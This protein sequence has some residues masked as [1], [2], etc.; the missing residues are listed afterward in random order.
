MVNKAL[1][2]STSK[3]MDADG[4]E[5]AAQ[6]L[7]ISAVL[8]H[9]LLMPA[10]PPENGG[11]TA[12]FVSQMIRCFSH[13]DEFADWKTE[14]EKLSKALRAA[15]VDGGSSTTVK[16]LSNP[17]WEAVHKCL[18]AR[19]ESKMDVQSID[20]L[21]ARTLIQAAGGDFQLTQEILRGIT[22]LFNTSKL[23]RRELGKFEWRNLFDVMTT[24][25]SL[26]EF[27]L[28]LSQGNCRTFGEQ[29]D[30][31]MHA[32]LP[33]LSTTVTLRTLYNEEAARQS[34]LH[35]ITEMSSERISVQTETGDGEGEGEGEGNVEDLKSWRR[36]DSVSN[37]L[38]HQSPF[39]PRRIKLG[40]EVR[41][42]TA[43]AQLPRIARGLS[44]RL[45]DAS[46]PQ[47]ISAS[48]LAILQT[49]VPVPAP[50]MLGL[51]LAQR[52]DEHI[53][54]DKNSLCFHVRRSH[55]HPTS[56]NTKEEWS[57]QIPP[58]V[59]TEFEK[60]FK[61]ENSAKFLAD[62]LMTDGVEES[63]LLKHHHE[64][65][66]ICSDANLQCWPGHWVHGLRAAAVSVL[67]SEL[68][69]AFTLGIPGLAS[70]GS[71]HYFHPRQVDLDAGSKEWYEHLGL[72]NV[73]SEQHL[74]E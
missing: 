6:P 24:G 30:R 2:L 72:C 8:R 9:G 36:G 61:T 38:A 21:L 63:E 10:R 65:L 32:P 45:W 57:I 41:S 19:Q 26:S 69:A 62:I 44:A 7:S 71:L 73:A 22:Q 27:I 49:A 64:L 55:M 66:R 50:V 37:Y 33:A 3:Q 51:G 16:H 53:Y 70:A 52:A 20:R 1:T 47:E 39:T 28:S 40:A 43:L 35:S 17:M 12:I 25:Q 48:L 18:K 68:L 56:S 29:A 74:G 46:T 15:G 60:R 23:H 67:N 11:G 31:L 13:S 14:A 5:G 34:A 4:L 54:F 59:R 58:V 42:T